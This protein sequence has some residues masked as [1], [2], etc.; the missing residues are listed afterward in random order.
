MSYKLLFP[1]YRARHRWALKTLDSLAQFGNP[2]RV[3]NVGCGEGD[4][5]GALRERAVD[6][7]ACDLNEG[8]VGH[9][10][11]LTAGTGV[12]YVVASALDLPFD[13]G[14]FDVACCFE[15]IEHVAEPRKCLRELARIVRPGGHVMLT[16]PNARFPVTYDPINWLLARRGSHLNIG[17]FGFGHDWLVREADLIEW[18]AAAGLHPVE[19]AHLT[20]TLAAAF[21][22]YWVGLLQR[23]VKANARNRET[24]A[25]G[26]TSHSRNWLPAMRPARG[27]PRFLGVTDAINALDEQL[28]ER[29]G[30]AV[31]LAFLF[32]RADPRDASARV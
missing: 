26:A 31:G 16:C 2:P 4:I 22:A 23:L 7:V 15:V 14:S 28:F 3:I 18:A 24:S 27:R 5:D 8:D 17:A 1:T 25:A 20:K 13:D 29:S 19:R 32:A 21:E 11:V 10:R 9:A 30:T 6:L 12:E